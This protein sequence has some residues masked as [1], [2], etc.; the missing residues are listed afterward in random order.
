ML[1]ITG[2]FSGLEAWFCKLKGRMHILPILDVAS[3]YDGEF[4]SARSSAREENE[5][6]S[7]D[8]V[9]VGALRWNKLRNDSPVQR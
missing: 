1:A 5:V 2:L 7:P 8:H 6:Y 3:E 4:I 9:V